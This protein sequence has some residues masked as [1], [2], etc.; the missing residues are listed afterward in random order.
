[1]PSDVRVRQPAHALARCTVAVSLG[2]L[3]AALSQ[4]F[5]TFTR[6][7]DDVVCGVREVAE[8]LARQE[9]GDASL[10]VTGLCFHPSPWGE[11]RWRACFPLR[12][13]DQ[14]QP[15]QIVQEIASRY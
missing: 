14:H 2:H 10:R 15:L 8:E 1:M 12:S 5:L 13:S 3:L 11:E 6:Q 7:F 9:V 4:D